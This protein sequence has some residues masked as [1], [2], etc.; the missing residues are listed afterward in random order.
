MPKQVDHHGRRSLIADALMR[1]AAEHGPEAVSLRN[2]AA[3]AGVS[4][5]MVQHYFGTKDEMMIFALGVIRDNIQARL[6]AEIDTAPP[7]TLLRTLLIQLLPLDETRRTEGRVMLT[8]MTYA[9][10]HPRV[11]TVLRTANAELREF[12]AGWL[13]T[14]ER[15]TAAV[16]LA[17]LVD[18]LALQVL[19][20]AYSPET[21]LAAF[22]AQLALVVGD[23]G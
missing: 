21:A 2:I 19:T 12:I 9:A 8:A 18:G 4:T 23:A 22:D 10:A 11:A 13:G 15:E 16:A 6:A 3:A 14:P 1:V 7:A 20:G 5:G 17:A